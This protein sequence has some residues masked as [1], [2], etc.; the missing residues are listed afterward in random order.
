MRVGKCEC[1]C[2]ERAELQVGMSYLAWVLG[3]ELRTSGR[4]GS[5]LNPGA[6]SPAL[7]Y[8]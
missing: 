1:G 3:T 4:A 8:K 2:Q 5:T 6:L 7:L